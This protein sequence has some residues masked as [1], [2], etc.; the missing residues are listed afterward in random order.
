MTTQS[1]TLKTIKFFNTSGQRQRN[2]NI[3]KENMKAQ[4]S[5]ISEREQEDSQAVEEEPYTA[6]IN[7]ESR[8]S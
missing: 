3:D 1:Q 5:V 6:G 7:G 2:Q 4:T 8:F